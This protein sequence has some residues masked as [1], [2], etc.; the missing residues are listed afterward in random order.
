MEKKE[1]FIRVSTTLYKIVN[2][3]CHYSP[4]RGIG[5]YNTVNKTQLEK[6]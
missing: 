4:I 6:F 3:D 1:E 5:R 2:R